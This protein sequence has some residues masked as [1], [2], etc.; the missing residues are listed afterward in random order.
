[1]VT[2]LSLTVSETT[3]ALPSR[4]VS[5]ER[6]LYTD[7][8]H[9][10]PKA[11]KWS[12]GGVRGGGGGFPFALTELRTPQRGRGDPQGS[13]EVTQDRSRTLN[14]VVCLCETPAGLAPACAVPGHHCRLALQFR[15]LTGFPMALLQTIP[16]R[17]NAKLNHLRA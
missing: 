9:P 13:P 5:C 11:S 17:S 8:P 14:V 7:T 3:T 1:M 6:R 12:G 4:A 16:F 2:K 10:H 15:P